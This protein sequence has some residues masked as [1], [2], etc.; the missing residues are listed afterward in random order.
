[1]SNANAPKLGVLVSGGAPTLHLAAG[2]LCAF[3]EHNVQFQVLAAA[4][5]GAL[6]ALLYMVPKK[7]DPETALKS[8]VDINIHDAI[9]DLIPS[10]Y[11]VFFK[12]GPVAPLFWQLGQMIPHFPLHPSERSTNAG[13]RLYND[14]IDLVTAAITPTTLN[15]WSKSVL[16]RVQV[17]ND[18]VDWNA[19]PNAPQA[20]FLNT[21]SLETQR[22]EKFDKKTMTPD[23]FYAALAMPWLYPP[24]AATVGGPLFT[25]GASH[26][27]SAIEAA[28]QNKPPSTVTG[29]DAMIVIDTIG[30]D[31]W[32]DPESLYEALELTIMDPIVTLA[33]N[34]AAL[35]AAQDEFFNME[36]PPIPNFSPPKAYRLRFEIPPWK[37]G[38][39]LE[40]TYS[41][42]VTLWD[43]GYRAAT[44]FC[45]EG[46]GGTK[47]PKGQPIQLQEK[48]RYL[49]TLSEDSREGDFLSLMGNVFKNLPGA[50]VPPPGG[51]S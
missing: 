22:L 12:Y 39:L 6:P 50:R 46:D 38:K 16:N 33:E 31:L 47:V 35:Y 45:E 17:V 1:V 20:F 18:L 25:E 27:P 51:G 29:L 30:S 19:L 8:L 11:K 42:A 28:L 48:N 15:Y 37:S 49:R 3:H 32:V 40:W 10:N 24:T 26:D 21:F 9:Y 44:K 7:T 36:P 2:A 14:F 34:V 5:A 43:T 41:N 13:K 4:G 23:A